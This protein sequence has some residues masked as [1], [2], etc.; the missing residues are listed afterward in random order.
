ME[1]VALAIN[2]AFKPNKVIK[3]E[4]TNAEKSFSE[5]CKVTKKKTAK[6]ETNKTQLFVM[7][8]KAVV[9]KTII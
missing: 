3:I 2:T 6:I 7:T 5:N 9:A 4:C 8:W 1:S